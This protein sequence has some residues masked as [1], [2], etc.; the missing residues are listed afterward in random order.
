MSNPSPLSFAA[1]SAAQS[2]SFGYQDGLQRHVSQCAK[3]NGAWHS[4]RCKVETA[5]AFMSGRFVST[6]VV[7]SGLLALSAYW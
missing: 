2:H 4:V 7:A 1:N 6:I 3:E 5:D